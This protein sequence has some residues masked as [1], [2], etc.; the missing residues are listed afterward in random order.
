MASDLS[1]LRGGGKADKGKRSASA[2]AQPPPS[3]VAG[4]SGDAWDPRPYRPI[5]VILD[6]SVN[7]L[8]AHL[9]KNCSKDD[10]TCPFLV[11]EQIGFEMDKKF[12]ETK[13]QLLLSP[14]LLR[15]GALSSKNREAVQ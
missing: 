7:N 4:V 10:L 5:E 11:V 12:R 8:V 6:L 3:D 1:V 13:L 2:H 14:V 15:S 9:I